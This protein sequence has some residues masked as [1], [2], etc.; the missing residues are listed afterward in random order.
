MSLISSSKKESCKALSY[1]AFTVASENEKLKWVHRYFVSAVWPG[2]HTQCAAAHKSSNVVV[3]T[4]TPTQPIA[5]DFLST[6]D[7]NLFLTGVCLSTILLSIHNN[8]PP[9][10]SLLSKGRQTNEVAGEKESVRVGLGSPITLLTGSINPP[11]PPLLTPLSL[12]PT[13][14]NCFSFSLLWAPLGTA[15]P[16]SLHCLA[17]SPC[18]IPAVGSQSDPRALHSLARPLFPLS[19][20][21]P[22]VFPYLVYT[23]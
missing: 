18:P 2:P 1:S 6:W 16:G 9:S 10:L 21:N 13:Q 14:S 23:G 22:F 12:W 20:P 3:I 11:G 5:L 4:S 17:A 19:L 8:P 15:M 7:Q